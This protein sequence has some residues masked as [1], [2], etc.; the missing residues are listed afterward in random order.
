MLAL[1]DAATDVPADLAPPAGDDGVP[2]DPG[3]CFASSPFTI[4]PRAPGRLRLPALA[5]ADDEVLV[6]T[7]RETDD[8]STVVA[9]P[10]TPV[11]AVD[12]DSVTL[13]AGRGGTV[14]PFTLGWTEPGF[15]VAYQDDAATLAAGRLSLDGTLVGAS[16]TGRAS[17]SVRPLLVF[18]PSLAVNGWVD[19]GVPSAF[20]VRLPGGEPVDLDLPGVGMDGAQD[21]E[22]P[23]AFRVVSVGAT[24]V[25]V[26]RWSIAG[27]ALSREDVPLRWT[28]TFPTAVH[29]AVLLDDEPSALAVF[30]GTVRALDDGIVEARVDAADGDWFFGDSTLWS[31]DAAVDPRTRWLGLAVA[32]LDWGGPETGVRFLGLHPRGDTINVPVSGP[33]EVAGPIEVAIVDTGLASPSFLVVWVE[34]AAAG[35]RVRA[36]TIGCD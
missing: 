20:V 18:T 2:L 26:Q 19:G 32:V 4:E 15:T 17:S 8:S 23:D 27:E 29:R 22:A 12:G 3:E 35:G 21:T 30:A 33:V 25:V 9:R 1:G 24:G 5:R 7:T 36:A 34:N 31:G 11:G 10:L 13:G 28:G 14:V 16:S 6:V